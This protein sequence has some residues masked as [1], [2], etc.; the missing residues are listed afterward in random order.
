MKI[1]AI[2]RWSTIICTFVRPILFSI[3]RC[4]L[5]AAIDTRLF[6]IVPNTNMMLYDTIWKIKRNNIELASHTLYH[7]R[8][9]INHP[10]SW[11]IHDMF[12]TASN[13]W[14]FDYSIPKRR[15]TYKCKLQTYLEYSSTCILSCGSRIRKTWSFNS[16]VSQRNIDLVQRYW[17]I[18][19]SRLYLSYK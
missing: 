11:H 2:V 8:K 15:W 7:D 6:P 1:P 5:R 3:L 12:V 17:V 9:R 19:I 13:K 16:W 14:I 18:H 4:C 10:K